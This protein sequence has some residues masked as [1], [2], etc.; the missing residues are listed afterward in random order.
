M[1]HNQATL[2]EG[3]AALGTRFPAY[4]KKETERGKEIKTEVGTEIEIERG[5]ETEE[6]RET[7]IKTES[8]IVPVVVEEMKEI[9]IVPLERRGKEK[10]DNIQAAEN[11][12]FQRGPKEVEKR[13][14]AI[15]TGSLRGNGDGMVVQ[16]SRHLSKISMGLTS[17]LSSEPLQS[18]PPQPLPPYLAHRDLPQP[19]PVG[20]CRNLT[21]PTRERRRE[22]GIQLER[23]RIEEVDT[24][25]PSHSHHQGITAMS[26]TTIQ[27][28]WRLM[29]CL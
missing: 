28:N 10:E 21:N 11:A 14:K 13:G 25:D 24:A 3:G 23:W 8:K 7:E 1:L 18:P 26:Q 2:L 22:N 27:I 19:L 9:K 16:L 5:K 4:L 17:L 20:P 29:C 6:E 15:E 12:I